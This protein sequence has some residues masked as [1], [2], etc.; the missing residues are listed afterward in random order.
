LSWEYK[1]YQN[2]GFRVNEPPTLV[3]EHTAV[4]LS[5][6]TH[7]LDPVQEEGYQ[8]ESF[9]AFDE[10]ATLLLNWSRAEN[11]PLRIPAAPSLPAQA[12]I[13]RRFRE[14]YAEAGA[15]LGGAHVAAFADASEDGLAG[16]Y[17]VEAWG[18]EARS[19]AWRFQTLEVDYERLCGRRSLAGEEFPFTDTYIA[20]QW[21]WAGRATVAASRQ[22]TDDPADAAVDTSSGTPRR[23]YDALTASV[24]LGNHNEIEAFWGKRRE[25]L[26]CT[27]GTCYLVRAFDGVILRLLTRF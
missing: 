26:Q 4:L 25:G 22:T 8:F 21:D 23:T 12:Y 18:A 17:G 10:H 9:L 27:A 2:F 11:K 6:N 7:V 15:D 1:D 3:R 24:R 5:R 19:P 13:P 20:L 14:F 16:L